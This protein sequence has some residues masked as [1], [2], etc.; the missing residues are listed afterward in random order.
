[1]LV[2]MAQSD[3]WQSDF[4]G[5]KKTGL[6]GARLDRQETYDPLFLLW[7]WRLGAEQL[8]YSHQTEEPAGSKTP[9][10]KSNVKRMLLACGGLDNVPWNDICGAVRRT[11]PQMPTT[12][13]KAVFL[14]MTGHSVDNER[15]AWFAGEMTSFLGL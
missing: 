12:P 9:R 7:H 5:C 2:P 1:M 3:T 8:L 4:Y 13:G 10:F 15:R 11:A 6:V 14:E